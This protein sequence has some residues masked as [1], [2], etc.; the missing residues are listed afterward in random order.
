MG[1]RI[2]L[3]LLSLTALFGCNGSGGS[4]DPRIRFFQA[5]A[6]SQAYSFFVDGIVTD[7][8]TFNEIGGYNSVDEGTRT[9]RADSNGTT[10]FNVQASIS[11]DTDYTVVAV[12]DGGTVTPVII[13]DDND[14]PD[15]NNFRIRALNA[16]DRAPLVDVYVLHENESVVDHEPNLQSVQFKQ[17]SNYDQVDTTEWVIWVTAAGTKTVL[18]SAPSQRF[19]EQEIWTAF[20]S[21]DPNGSGI[22]VTLNQDRGGI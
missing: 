5:A 3:L 17:A 16:A 7:T 15:N 21:D 20:I 1:K 9:L 8:V 22:V 19:D 2:T 13:V 4:D 6:P 18:A 11:D 10:L 14:R 12:N